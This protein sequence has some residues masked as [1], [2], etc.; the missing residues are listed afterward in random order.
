MIEIDAIK[1]LDE[2]NRLL[3]EAYPDYSVYIDICPKQFERPSFLLELMYKSQKDASCKILEE[4]VYYT[5]TCYDTTDDYARSSTVN[6]L[7]VQQGVMDIFKAG[8]IRVDDRAIKVKAS[9]GGRD[10]DEAYIDLQF[11]YY[12]ERSKEENVLPLMKELYTS[13]KEE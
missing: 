11:E 8:Y 4:I 5:I 10:F 6:L 13:I 12:T 1:I 7:T 9:A 3:V 2:I